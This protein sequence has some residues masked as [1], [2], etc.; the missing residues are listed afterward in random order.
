MWE[1][2]QKKPFID[3][4]SV[5]FTDKQGITPAL[6]PK[7]LQQHV[8]L[9]FNENQS[10]SARIDL[11]TGK[12]ERSSIKDSIEVFGTASTDKLMHGAHALVLKVSTLSKSGRK[13]YVL[14]LIHI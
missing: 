11:S 8:L 1:A 9:A 2:P 10:K 13:S 4:S 5:F 12:I 14:S 3:N 6:F 7:K